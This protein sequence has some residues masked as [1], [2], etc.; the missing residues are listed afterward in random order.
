MIKKNSFYKSGLLSAILVVLFQFSGCEVINPDEEIPSYLYIPKITLNTDYPSQGSNSNGIA[1]GWVYVDDYL[2]GVFELPATIPVTKKGY[3]K[4]EIRAGIRKN[5]Q[6]NSRIYYPFYS[7]YVKYTTLAPKVTD[8]LGPIVVGY[9]NN[10]NFKLIEGFDEL[11]TKFEITKRFLKDTFVTVTNPA[12]VF[13]GTGGSG[14]LEMKADTSSILEIATISEYSLP[15]SGADVFV[16]LDYKCDFQFTLGYIA[17]PSGDIPQYTSII[18]FYPTD[19]IWKKAYI[20]LKEDIGSQAEGTK[21]KLFMGSAKG[22][23]L[24]QPKIYIDN[25]KLVHFE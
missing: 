6:S 20:S 8:T 19:S 14:L 16:E 25:V 22:G 12:E 10:I 2:I 18:T 5:G 1:D 24:Y 23:K 9:Q 3:C 13:G 15:G 17:I 7:T 11:S 21:Y 4:I